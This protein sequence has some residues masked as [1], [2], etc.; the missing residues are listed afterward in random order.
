MSRQTEKPKTPMS[1][2]GVD[3]NIF[4]NLPFEALNIINKNQIVNHFKRGQSIF[5]AGNFP[6]CLYC[7]DSGVVKIET[8]GANGNGH[9]L[10]VVRAGD[11]LGYRAL[12]AEE[13]YEGTAVVHD[14][15][16]VR[17]IP[18]A[19]INELVSKFPEVA[20][21]ML[22]KISKELRTIDTRLCA[23]C[24]KNATE[25]IADAL[26]FLKDNFADQTWTRKEIGEWAGTAPE[27]VMRTLADFEH[28]GLIEQQ[29]RKIGICAHKSLVE[30]ANSAYR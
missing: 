10:R 24:D 13:P 1:S 30:K 18:K 3:E 6:G 15:A 14:D 26:L 20:L 23:Q 25:R 22:S 19:A 4:A 5:Y 29:G 21:R 2:D 12:F 17:I 16:T 8:V 7:V 28:E 27:T 11:I 9:I